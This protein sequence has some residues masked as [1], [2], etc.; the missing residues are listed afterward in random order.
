MGALLRMAD[1]LAEAM[2]NEAGTTAVR[3]LQIS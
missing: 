2:L 1:H 3:N